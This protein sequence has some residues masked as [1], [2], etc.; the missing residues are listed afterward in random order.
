MTVRSQ[1]EA[2]IGSWH[3]G[4]CAGKACW[5][6]PTATDTEATLASGLC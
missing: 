5:I 2:S 1:K 3:S 4:H 6:H